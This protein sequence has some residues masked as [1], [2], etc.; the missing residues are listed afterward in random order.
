MALPKLDIESLSPDE[1]LALIERIWDS[2]TSDDVG[3]SP[4]QHEEL[5]RRLEDVQRHPDDA[6]EW[7]E[8][9]RRIREQKR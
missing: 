2:L 8:A 7:D 4:A 3:L 6:V 1:R 9:Q 5:A